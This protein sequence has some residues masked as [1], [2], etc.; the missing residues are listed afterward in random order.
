[1]KQGR[2]GRVE[3]GRCSGP[4]G[5]VGQAVWGKRRVGWGSYEPDGPVF[6]LDSDGPVFGAARKMRGVVA[7][8][9]GSKG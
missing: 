2:T 9:P 6:G 4:W 3:R 7:W 5:G 1:M 8:W